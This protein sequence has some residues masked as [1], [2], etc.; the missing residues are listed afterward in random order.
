M[1]HSQ[2]SQQHAGWRLTDFT[3][4]TKPINTECE[5]ETDKDVIP[6][7][8]KT[9][10]P[11]L[12]ISEVRNATIILEEGGILT[13]EVQVSHS[14]RMWM[15]GDK[16]MAT[17]YFRHKQTE[18]N[19]L[20]L[21]SCISKVSHSPHPTL[22]LTTGRL[23]VDMQVVLHL[24]SHSCQPN[25]NKNI[26]MDQHSKSKQAVRYRMWQSLLSTGGI[27]VYLGLVSNQCQKYH[28]NL[29]HKLKASKLML[30]W[31]GYC[32]LSQ[33]KICAN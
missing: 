31:W 18:A 7:S 25:I 26:L 17:G 11:A 4:Q 14:L 15:Y 32:I 6:T 5:S 28:T 23:Y 21:K 12:R 19:R 22:P 16:F 24:F 20:G 2:T 33:T 8:D 9:V 29:H 10:E 13:Q 30:I 1:W 27:A 3:G